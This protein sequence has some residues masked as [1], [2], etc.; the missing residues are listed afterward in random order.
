MLPPVEAVIT[1]PLKRCQETAQLLYPEITPVIIKDF[2][3]T[4]F[5]LFEGKN[6]EELMADENLAPLYQAWIDAGGKAPFPEGESS[7]QV[8]MRCVKAF[9]K[10]LPMLAKHA[11]TAMTV[12]VREDGS[13]NHI[14][15]FDPTSGELL[16]LP[17]GQGY[18]NV[19]HSL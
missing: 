6:Y 13:C 8:K 19:S 9:G 7:E 1:S 16:D 15:V 11:H 3:E 4:D 10:L 18:G 14:A 2:R 12:L 17:G 5:G